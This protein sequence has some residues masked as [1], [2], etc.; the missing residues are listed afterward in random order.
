MKKIR[1]QLR[2]ESHKLATYPT[3]CEKETRSGTGIGQLEIG[4]ATC[5]GRLDSLG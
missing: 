4:A 2:R 5:A 1:W 3:G